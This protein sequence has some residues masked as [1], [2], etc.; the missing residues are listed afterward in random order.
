MLYSSSNGCQSWLRTGG[1]YYGCGLGY[2]ST[3]ASIAACYCYSIIYCCNRYS[4][5]FARR[6]LFACCLARCFSVETGSGYMS[7]Q[8]GVTQSSIYTQIFFLLTDWNHKSSKRIATHNSS[9]IHDVL[10]CY[11]PERMKTQVWADFL[12]K[13]SQSVQ[14]ELKITQLI[15]MENIAVKSISITIFLVYVN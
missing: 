14:C 1:L 12:W 2:S 8:T 15:P 11:F 7:I 5:S 4:F 10:R 6:F 9:V 3:P 13:E